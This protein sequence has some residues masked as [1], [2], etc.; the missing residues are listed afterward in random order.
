MDCT[1][2]SEEEQQERRVSDSSMRRNFVVLL[3]LCAAVGSCVV[4]VMHLRCRGACHGGLCC[5][6]WLRGHACNTATLRSIRT[7]FSVD[8]FARI[9]THGTLAPGSGIS[10]VT[11]QTPPQNVHYT[12]GGQQAVPSSPGTVIAEDTEGPSATGTTVAAATTTDLPEKQQRRK[13]RNNA[14]AA[15]AGPRKQQRQQQLTLRQK[16]QKQRVVVGTTALSGRAKTRTTATAQKKM[17]G[18]IPGGDVWMNRV[19]YRCMHGGEAY[20]AAWLAGKQGVL[21]RRLKVEEGTHMEVAGVFDPSPTYWPLKSV[22]NASLHTTHHI[23]A[24]AHIHVLG[25]MRA[26]PTTLRCVSL[27]FP[28]LYDCVC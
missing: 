2:A 19:F 14:T 11:T 5:C 18:V 1:M 8:S 23:H 28:P 17:S 6:D 15:G 20:G 12:L 10:P 24:R 16:Q 22:R 7:Q 25:N 9:H 27:A 4:C 3:G 26:T 13:T 21:N